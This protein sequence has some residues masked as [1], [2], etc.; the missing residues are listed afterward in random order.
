MRYYGEN[1]L[2]LIETVGMVPALYGCDMMLK[3]A[4]VELISY[5]NIGSTL[6]TVMVKGD[7]AA[8]KAAVE[9]GAAA[10]ASIGTLTA[11]NVMARPISGVGDIVSCHDIDV[12]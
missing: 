8:V 2:G 3:A 11:S 6:V 7:V 1:A 9:A 10:A 5:E 4:D 12:E